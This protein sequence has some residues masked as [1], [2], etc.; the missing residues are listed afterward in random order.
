MF[1]KMS[2]RSRVLSL[3][4]ALTLVLMAA[5]CG[6][7]W[8]QSGQMI[9]VAKAESTELARA[10][11][12]HIA[13]GVYRMCSAQQRLMERKVRADLNV[14]NEV[15]RS[16]GKVRLG[17]EMVS[18]EAVNQCDHR[19]VSTKLPKMLVG[20]VWLGQ[21]FD[22]RTTAPVVDHVKS[23][24]GDTCTIFQRMN[25]AGDM[26]RVCTN[27]VGKEGHRAIG[28]YIPAVE[29]DGTPNPVISA[30]LNG[31]VFVG[32]V[33]VV[34][35][36]Y[37]AAYRPILDAEQNVIGVL[38]VGVK[39]GDVP[40]LH[41]GIADIVVGKTGYVFV[42]GGKGDQ[43]GRY[44]VS[45]EGQRD[46][47]IVWK[48]KDENGR[49]VVQAIVGKALATRNGNCDFERYLW[50]NRGEDCARQK[51][52]AL[53][54]F[55]PWDWVIGVGCYE[56]EFHEVSNKLAAIRRQSRFALGSA[57]GICL[58]AS[59]ILWLYTTRSIT[60]PLQNIFRGL[61]SFST[62]ELA[63]TG[64]RFQVIID[65]LR[66]GIGELTSTAVQVSSAAQ[67]LAQG[68][69]EQNAAADVTTNRSKEIVAKIRQNVRHSTEAR[70]SADT[71][72]A[73][74]GKGLQAVT[75]M[76]KAFAN[77][78]K[79]IS[80]ASKT[81]KVIDEIA[82]QTNLLAVQA[83]MEAAHAGEAG[84][85]LA[86]VAEE[87][88][89]LAQRSAEASK[90]AAASIEQSI[91]NAADGSAVGKG[92]AGTFCG[93]IENS[94]KMNGLADEIATASDE[95]TRA[96]ELIGGAIGQICV[97]TEKNAVSAEESA[98]A[99]EELSSQAEELSDVVRQLRMLLD[100][101]EVE[102]EHK[103]VHRSAA[104]SPVPAKACVL[105][106]NRPDSK[107]DANHPIESPPE[108]SAGEP[109]EES[110]YTPQGIEG[111]GSDEGMMHAAPVVVGAGLNDQPIS[112]S[113]PMPVTVADLM[114][115]QS[116]V[117]SR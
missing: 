60:R 21:D 54:Y 104:P 78:H 90:K 76:I 81:M 58:L 23:L 10:D 30:V 53:T 91:K 83:A 25:D 24:V 6:V 38:Y 103:P 112:P 101:T 62:E 110:G 61:K 42:V 27:V 41:K 59:V 66:Q 67:L 95:Q 80:E 26:L 33:Y 28:T 55:E 85:S 29:P 35:A 108:A 5:V 17:S 36:W 82:I 20:D 34:D 2:L 93:M 72:R 3:G 12:V 48:V 92:V 69:D 115:E 8:W 105:A 97:T 22:V 49:Y 116:G 77:I 109:Q 14:A 75:R 114:V 64:K 70:N 51:I 74:A 98:A 40:E 113:H 89:H 96:I 11:L 117:R 47:E 16:K 1:K 43:R 37:V 50:R 88:R 73:S 86:V 102:E 31:Q 9:E 79:S 56:D 18:W 32:H 68:S 45:C 44:I 39:L 87:V 13:Q 63:A 46:G 7:V 111:G 84:K 15:L 4:V 107:S 71:A 99:A 106:P 57:F 19:L 94:R 65:T 52:A 100:G